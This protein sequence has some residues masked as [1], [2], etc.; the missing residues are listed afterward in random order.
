M[1]KI[2][3]QLIDRDRALRIDLFRAFGATMSREHTLP[4]PLAPLARVVSIE[5]LAARY[6]SHVYGHLLENYPVEAKQ[7]QAFRRL[8]CFDTFGSIEMNAAW[9]DHRQGRKESFFQARGAVER[10]LRL[11]PEL[12]FRQ[13][14]SRVLFPC[15]RCLDY[16]P[17][18]R[19]DPARIVDSLGYW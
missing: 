12:L 2:L 4:G 18:R 14:Y 3:L 11:R 10:L 8:A 5:D 19:A 6:T 7:A 13:K 1:R 17:F 16:G 9:H 15:D